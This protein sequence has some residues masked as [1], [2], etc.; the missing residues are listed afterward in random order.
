[1][2][3]QKFLLAAFSAFV[4]FTNAQ[5]WSLKISSHIGFRKYIVDTKAIKDETV[6]GGASIKLYKGDK[7]VDQT[8]SDGGGYFSIFVP[9]NG[10]YELRVTMQ[11]CFTKK[12]YINTT[13]VPDE[14]QKFDIKPSISI[15]GF[16]LSKPLP[17]IDYS[18]L[19]QTLA[20]IVYIPKDK[21]FG[22]EEMY[23]KEGL[24]LVARIEEAEMA[25]INSFCESNKAGDE[26]MKKEDCVLA[27]K[28]YN[29][30]MTLLPAEQYPV[31]QMTKVG[32]C[33]KT[34]E[35]I[36][37]KAEEM[38]AKQAL[39]EKYA[40]ALK[41]ADDAFNTKNWVIAKEGYTEALAVKANEQYPKYKLGAVDKMMAEETVAKNNL[42]KAAEVK[43]KYDAAVKRAEELF[44]KKLWTD[45]EDAYYE[46]LGFMPNEK[47][48][49][50]QI[51]AINKLLS[52]EFPGND[53]KYKDA[54]AKT[55]KLEPEY[56]QAIK[57][58]YEEALTYESDASY[59]KKKTNEPE[60]PVK[61]SEHVKAML[62]KYPQGLTE[63]IINGNGVVIVKRILIKDGDA[64]VY[65]KKI[66][67][68]GGITCFRDDATITESIFENET[69]M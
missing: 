59:L 65:Q 14:A 69:K 12:I 4:L 63:E 46:A 39:E 67:N 23:T 53:K 62:A 17:G 24:A 52:R 45:A 33:F 16:I 42:A 34:R 57:K 2:N 51:V 60:A 37:K 47:Y 31:T 43:A 58:T 8:F 36:A 32:D 6:L 13:G 29:N 3:K 38:V 9:A 19:E 68:W 20:K 56:V 40:E 22:D 1:M 48:P 54:I 55:S 64:W 26:A 25:L 30:A 21:N 35:E 7:V 41:K 5:N 15:E 11:G 66:F 28:M 50:T 44:A 18:S 10:E 49:K 61:N 27:K